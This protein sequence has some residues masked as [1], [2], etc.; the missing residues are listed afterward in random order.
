MKIVTVSK[1]SLKVF[2][3]INR[4][5]KPKCLKLMFLIVWIVII[6]TNTFNNTIYIF[7]SFSM[8]SFFFIYFEKFLQ[9]IM[10]KNNMLSFSFL[11][12]VDLT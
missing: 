8:Y 6:N 7:F 12:K 9:R 3:I 4:I 10:G 5:L 11:I 2:Y 1:Y